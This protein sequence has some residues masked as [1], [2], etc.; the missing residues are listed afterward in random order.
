MT[1][2]HDIDL[3]QVALTAPFWRNYQALVRQVVLPYQWEALNDR[4]ADA[5]PSHAIANFRIAAGRAE[6]R[7][8]GMIFQD[9]DVAKWLEAVAYVLCQQRDPALE[10]AA[11][12]VIE[13]IAA[14]QQPDGYLNT[15]FTLVAPAERWSNLAEC[16]ELYCAG[17]L[18]EAGVAYVRATGKRT[19]LEVCCRF[20]DHIAT[21]FGTTPGQLQGYPGHP[22][23]ELALLRLYEATDNAR[24]LALARYFI[25]QRGTQPH[26]YDE[27]YQRRGRT[28]YWDNHGSGWMVHDKAYSQAH[29]PVVQQQHATGHAVRF[30]YLMTGVAHLTLLDGDADKREACLRLWHD[31]AQRQLYVTGGIGAQS[32]GESFTSAYDLPNETAYAESCASI[33]LMLFAKRMLQLEGDARFA[34]VM[35]RALYNTV[36]AGMSLDGKAF[37]YVNPLETLPRTLAGSHAHDHV[38][39]VRQRWFGCACCPPNI[40]RLLASLGQYLYTPREDA[41]YVDLYAGS[42]VTLERDGVRITL[43]QRTDYPWDGRVEITLAAE[44]AFTTALALRIPDWCPQPTLT[45]DDAPLAFARRNGYAVAAQRWQPG[46]RLVLDLPMPVRRVSSHALLR[47]TAGKLA[48]Q[49]GPLVYCLEQVDNGS[50][51]YQLAL[52]HSAEFTL[53]PGSGSLTGMTLIEAD[54]LRRIDP[55][56]AE[57]LY[58]YDAAA[59]HWHAQRLRFVPY[60]AWGNRGEGEMRVWVE[61]VDAPAEEGGRLR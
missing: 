6:G 49:R 40:A 42:Q 33:G 14:A 18:F 35:E 21:T 41:L 55:S 59:P 60:F 17:H 29:L 45:L 53:V 31:M 44:R 48:V 2:T 30:A 3:T 32:W 26:W 43:S 13:L 7:F 23:I 57:A 11:D 39:P 52:P 12:A 8:H 22:E 19:L 61:A 46:Q 20:A 56:D 9:S 1:L 24:Y 15:Y 37:F 34:D 47:Q 36:L 51:L 5:E 16:H 54:G 38:K 27:E 58:R 4:I 28:A 10:E 25:D 50:E